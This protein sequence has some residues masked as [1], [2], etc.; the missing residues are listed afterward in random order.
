MTIPEGATDVILS[1]VRRK[2]AE[3]TV[4]QMLKRV[5]AAHEQFVEAGARDP[6]RRIWSEFPRD[7]S[8]VRSPACDTLSR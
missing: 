8:G 6:P 1:Y 7:R 5:Q 3:W 4:P 2:A